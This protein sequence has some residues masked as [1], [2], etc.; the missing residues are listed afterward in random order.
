[1]TA[2]LDSFQSRVPVPVVNSTLPQRLRPT[3]TLRQAPENETPK[4]G[5]G[6]QA[7]NGTV[8]SPIRD[9][10]TKPSRRNAATPRSFQAPSHVYRWRLDWLAEVAGFETLHSG[11]DAQPCG[12]A[13]R[14][15]SCL[16]T[17]LSGPQRFEIAAGL[18]ER[19][20]FLRQRERECWATVRAMALS[21]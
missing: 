17:K 21:R 3:G 8:S 15:Y 18:A 10:E 19:A 13:K 20:G 4:S 6:D 14:L 9:A 16:K 11:W 1:V 7:L 2:P 12:K 5:L